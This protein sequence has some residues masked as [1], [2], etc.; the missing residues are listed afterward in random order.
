MPD[1]MGRTAPAQGR[2]VER[3]TMSRIVVLGASGAMGRRVADLLSGQGHD[4]VRA[5]RS[6]GVDVVGGSGLAAAVSGADTV[7]DCLNIGTNARRRAVAF[8]A[9][10][11]QRVVTAADRAGVG[12]VVVL[13]IV[14]VTDPVV[15]SGLGYYVGKA[16]QE[17]TY[18]AGDVPLTVV[19]TTQWFDLAAQF[20][21]QSAAGPVSVV[22]SMMVQPVHP[23][24]A[25]DLLAQVVISEP[26]G[27]VQLAGPEQIRADEMARRLAQ[28]QGL[29]I[30]VVG[31]PFP[32]R[33]FRRSGLLPRGEFVSDPRTYAAWL[34]EQASLATVG[35][36]ER[37]TPE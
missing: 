24:A 27:R 13:S 7:V 19:A 32:G 16:A 21:T 25:A 36:T 10:A 34:A 37:V 33:A 30:R 2:P 3:G 1:T 26:Q 15:R 22:P 9:S 17:D 6:T 11:A 5:S 12:H 14:N 31:V 8:F 35:A 18:A 23:D 20:L 28:V 4:V 29:G